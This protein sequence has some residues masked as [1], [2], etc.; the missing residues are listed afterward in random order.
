MLWMIGAGLLGLT[1]AKLMLI[2]LANRNGF[3][4]IVAFITVGLITLAI[5]YFA[6]VPPKKIDH[7]KDSND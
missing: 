1:I 3:E 6:P 2:D 5:G 4:R 7:L